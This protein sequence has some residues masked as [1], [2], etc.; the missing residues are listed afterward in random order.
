MLTL[1]DRDIAVSPAFD[2]S[3]SPGGLIIPDTAKE[4]CDQGNVKYVGPNAEYV[5]PGDHVLFS[6]YDGTLLRVDGEG[7]VIILPENKIVSIL[8]PPRHN[9]GGIYFK[10]SLTDGEIEELIEEVMHITK[11]GQQEARTLVVKRGFQKNVYWPCTYEMTV[12][13]LADA[14]TTAPWKNKYRFTD[15]LS[16]APK[17][18][19]LFED[20]PWLK[21]N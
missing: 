2:P 21:R 17:R 1:K 6:A 15:R 9:V 18:H 10:S 12:E 14:V 3:K 4:R 13:L 8:N 16:T 7:L 5:L 20:S 11:C 19:E